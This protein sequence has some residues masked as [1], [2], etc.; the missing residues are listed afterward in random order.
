MYRK[1][2]GLKHP[3]GTAKV[4]NYAKTYSSSTGKVTDEG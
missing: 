3:E 2:E 1:P 4:Q